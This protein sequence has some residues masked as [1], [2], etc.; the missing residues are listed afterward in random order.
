ML[1]RFIGYVEMYEH[2]YAIWMEIVCCCCSW[3]FI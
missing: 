3:N 2:M 1:H